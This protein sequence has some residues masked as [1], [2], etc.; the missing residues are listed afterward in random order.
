MIEKKNGEVV[1]YELEPIQTN[2]NQTTTGVIDSF[3]DAILH[4]REPSVTGE[5]ALI[6]L[7]VVE[8][9]IGSK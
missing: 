5:Q 2:Y 7:K 9:I 4:D 3:I 8:K 6:T 1:K